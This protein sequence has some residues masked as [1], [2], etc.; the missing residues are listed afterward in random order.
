L[1]RHVLM[2]LIGSPVRVSFNQLVGG[3]SLGYHG[4]LLTL[5][6]T[7]PNLRLHRADENLFLVDA[8]VRSMSMPFSPSPITQNS[9]RTRKPFNPDQTI[10]IGL[11]IESNWPNKVWPQEEWRALLIELA[12]RYRANFFIFSEKQAG[13]NDFVEL[14]RPCGIHLQPVCVPLKKLKG[15]LSKMN[16]YISSDSGPMHVADDAGCTV[17][18]LFGPSDIQQWHPYRNGIQAVVHNQSACEYA[19]CR[20]PVC[21]IIDCRCIRIITPDMI[22]QKIEVLLK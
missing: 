20:V 18:S 5:S 6:I 4:R 8:W 9:P 13:V 10:N 15:E 17:I 21:K 12:K 11:N 1:R 3:R 16:L 7:P 14:I 19:P 22:L 2:M